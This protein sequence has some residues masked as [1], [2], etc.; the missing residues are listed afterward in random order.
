MS[1]E[2]E[3]GFDENNYDDPSDPERIAKLIEIGDYYSL[4]AEE[5][6]KQSSDVPLERLEASDIL[7]IE[8]IESVLGEGLVHEV[9]VG[10]DILSLPSGEG[11]IAFNT[12]IGK[13]IARIFLEHDV[14]FP[15]W[16]GRLSDKPGF[17]SEACRF[18]NDL[19]NGAFGSG[20]PLPPSC[21]IYF[22]GRRAGDVDFTDESN[23]AYKLHLA[24]V[25]FGDI[26]LNDIYLSNPFA[27][28][29]DGRHVSL[30]QGIF[31]EI[32]ISIESY[33]KHMEY[34]AISLEA[35]RLRNLRAFEKRGFVMENNK[36]AD[37]AKINGIGF[38]MR[39]TL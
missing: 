4:Q 2:D 7:P 12:P 30:G 20:I 36:L 17:Y 37:L 19:N 8:R 31:D 5:I 28:S 6:L 13:S 10:E 32:L 18:L 14:D 23:Y 29:R 16:L 22:S 3:I 21:Q 33:A 34:K 27:A 15:E 26:Y 9:V 24:D 11:V 1:I 35:F 25:L 39:K 38:P